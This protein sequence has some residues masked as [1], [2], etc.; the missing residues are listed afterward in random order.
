MKKKI[1]SKKKVTH[2]T[3]FRLD[4]DLH[5]KLKKLAV[6]KDM[7]VSGLITRATRQFVSRAKI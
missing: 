6:K 5:D 1:I 3:T 2:T 7:S 4:Q